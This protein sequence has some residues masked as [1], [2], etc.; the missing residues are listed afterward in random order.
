MADHTTDDGQRGDEQTARPHPT[1]SDP[2]PFSQLVGRG[3]LGIV[4]VLFLVFSLFNVHGVRFDWIFGEWH[5]APLILLL[6]GSFVLGAAVG[7]GAVWRRRRVQHAR[8]QRE[9]PGRS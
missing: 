1:T 5:G 4:A 3:V 2:A 8:W 9:E 6:L 7:A